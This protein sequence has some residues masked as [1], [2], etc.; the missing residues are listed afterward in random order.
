M[1]YNFVALYRCIITFEFL[2]SACV[3]YTALV[4]LWMSH[5]A[6]DMFA[7][8]FCITLQL[9]CIYC[10]II[11][12][13]HQIYCCIITFGWL[14]SPRVPDTAFVNL[15]HWR[16]TTTLI[17]QLYQYTQRIIVHFRNTKYTFLKVFKL[18]TEWD[19][20]Y[21]STCKLQMLCAEN[22]NWGEIFIL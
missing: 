21:L 22:P 19:N 4:H 6:F 17:K 11:T 16:P 3:P 7:L 15:S 14:P 8:H 18:K 1:H 12:L 2:P 13:L 5:L 9:C 10:C 20:K